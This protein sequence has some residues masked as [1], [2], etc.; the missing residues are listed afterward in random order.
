M[1]KTL[2]AAHSHSRVEQ[3]Q[4]IKYPIYNMRVLFT[5]SILLHCYMQVVVA[6]GTLASSIAQLPSCAVKLPSPLPG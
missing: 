6:E 1:P 3:S 4:K 5:I 2:G